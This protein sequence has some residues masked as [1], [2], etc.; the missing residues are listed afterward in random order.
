MPIILVLKCCSVK[1]DSRRPMNMALY[2]DLS[3]GKLGKISSPW[4]S[5]CLHCGKPRDLA[6]SCPWEKCIS[7]NTVSSARSQVTRNGTALEIEGLL[8]QNHGRP[9]AKKVQLPKQTLL[10]RCW[11]CVSDITGKAI[12][13]YPE[14][15]SVLYLP[16]IQASS[17]LCPARK[18]ESM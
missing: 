11:P 6:N 18:W 9:Q 15:I 3:S 1:L 2:S 14:T 17:L 4:R 5:T 8:G 7:N 10:W 12:Y 16:P 13:F